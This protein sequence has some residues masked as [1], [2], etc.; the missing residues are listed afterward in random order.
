MLLSGLTKRQITKLENQYKK[1]LYQYHTYYYH[2]YLRQ[3]N[4]QARQVAPFITKR[5]MQTIE[6]DE[7]SFRLIVTRHPFQRFNKNVI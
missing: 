1:Y 3:P 5:K 6:E 7:S 2:L 4:Q